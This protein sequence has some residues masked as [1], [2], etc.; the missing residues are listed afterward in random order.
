MAESSGRK[1]TSYLE[2][3]GVDEDELLEAFIDLGLATSEQ[4]ALAE[5]AVQPSEVP[6]RIASAFSADGTG[7]IAQALAVLLNGASGANRENIRVAI[8]SILDD[9]PPPIIAGRPIGLLLT[10]TR[11]N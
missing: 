11:I 6:S 10:L 7:N 9:A 2:N 8:Q 3:P 1:L 4:G 5:T